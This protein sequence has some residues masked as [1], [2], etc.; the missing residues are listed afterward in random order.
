M[1][2]DKL[3]SKVIV[4]RK[5]T[6][7]VFLFG[8]VFYL[9]ADLVVMRSGHYLKVDRYLL[10]GDKIELYLKSGGSIVVPV[11]KVERIVDDYRDTNPVKVIDFD[12]DFRESELPLGV[13]Y[14]EEIVSTARKYGISAKFVAAIIEIESSFNP[15]AI[16]PKGAIGLMQVMPATAER[17][18]VPSSYL[19]DVRWNLEAGVRYLRYLR[20]LFGDSVIEILASYN[21]GEGNVLRYRGV[22]PFQETKRYVDMIIYKL[23][24]RER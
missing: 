11:L 22:P 16:S 10:K 21:A 8:Y 14:E 9:N 4:M 6:F 18:G 12:L 24:D 5:F 17:F 1:F 7:T 2:F 13:P 3:E 15:S 23:S 20:K 19:L